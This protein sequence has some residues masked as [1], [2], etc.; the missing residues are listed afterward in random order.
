[1]A[2][3]REQTMIDVKEGKWTS[4]DLDSTDETYLNR[5]AIHKTLIN[6]SDVFCQGRENNKKIENHTGRRN[7]L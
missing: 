1:M 5:E 2:V 3:S 7:F 4:E 6:S